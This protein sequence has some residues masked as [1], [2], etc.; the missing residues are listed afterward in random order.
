MAAYD[1]CAGPVTHL[2]T[3]FST[4]NLIMSTNRHMSTNC[5]MSTNHHHNTR[6]VNLYLL[7]MDLTIEEGLANLSQTPELPSTS[8]TSNCARCHG[9]ECAGSRKTRQ[10]I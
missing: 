5:R 8:T 10:F 4:L 7:E 6:Y 9:P 1:L 2:T 3:S